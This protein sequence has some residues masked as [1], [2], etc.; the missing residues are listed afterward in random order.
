MKKIF[1]TIFCI[2]NLYNISS[3]QNVSDPIGF[4]NDF[5]NI[6][7]QEQK[8]E[9]ESTLSNFEQD[10]GNEI[11]LLIVK[12]LN[13]E[14]IEN[15]ANLAFEEW[16]IGKEERDNGILI[17]M[18]MEEKK[19]RIEVGYGLEST[20]TDIVAKNI[21]YEKIIPEFIKENYYNGLKEGV[22]EIINT[23]SSDSMNADANITNDKPTYN[24]IGFILIALYLI[25]PLLNTILGMTKSYWFG[26]LVG[27]T[28]GGIFGYMYN[29][30]IYFPI[31]GIIILGLLGLIYDYLLSKGIIRYRL[32]KNIFSKSGDSGG[33]GGFGGGSSG[34][35]GASGRW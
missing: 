30:L 29:P 7:N 6:L 31:A 22:L 15:Y 21:I 35:G 8:L 26:G 19:I 11:A 27:G 24:Y 20:I 12:N 1:F 28:I 32:G 14:T 4:V 3:A 33:F 13:G 17:V 18:S 16:K 2:F 23:I 34:G 9:L 25:L 10:T 5:A